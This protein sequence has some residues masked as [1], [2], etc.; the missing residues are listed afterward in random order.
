MVNKKG[1][2]GPVTIQMFLFVIVAF[3][4]ILFLGLY[5]FVFDTVTTNIGVDV[6]V[7]NVNLKN[8]TDSTLGQLNIALGLNADILGIILL[9]GM[10]MMMLLNGVFFGKR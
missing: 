8:V 6:D 3:F 1:V 9:L 4:V 10:V 5:V 2:Q 7:G